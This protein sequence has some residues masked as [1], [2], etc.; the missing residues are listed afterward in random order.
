MSLRLHLRYWRREITS[1]I[2]IS[3]DESSTLTLE[4]ICGDDG[5]VEKRNQAAVIPLRTISRQ[6][7]VRVSYM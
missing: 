1:W 5:L 6:H 7:A 2:S 3:E 4:L